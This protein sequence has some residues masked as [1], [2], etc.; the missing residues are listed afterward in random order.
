MKNWLESFL[1]HKPLLHRILGRMVR[2]DE[3]E[4]IVQETFL[5]SYTA[6]RKQ[7]IDNPRAFMARTATNIALNHLQRAENRLNCSLEMTGESPL[8]SVVESLEQQYQTREAFQEFCR[9]AAS[10]PP[11]CRK[12]F[13]LKKVYGMSQKE[14]AGY[15]GISSSTVE[16]HVA[17]GML[18]VTR[19]MQSRGQLANVRKTAAN[20]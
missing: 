18:M 12:V 8:E 17:K 14:I 16:K 10:L 1:A 4:D 5:Q 15:L 2:P 20:G 11:V 3:I 13:I 19:H 7:Q 9:A 6:A